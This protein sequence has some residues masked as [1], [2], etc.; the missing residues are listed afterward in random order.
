MHSPWLLHMWNVQILKKYRSGWTVDEPS[1][2]FTFKELK[3]KLRQ[4]RG[5]GWCAGINMSHEVN[6]HKAV[7]TSTKY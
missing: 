1:C 7:Y 6:C 3:G 2:S 5:N 4:E